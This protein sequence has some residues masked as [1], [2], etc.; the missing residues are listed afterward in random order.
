MEVLIPK[1]DTWWIDYSAAQQV[2]RLAGPFHD[3]GDPWQRISF[4]KDE[5]NTFTQGLRHLEQTSVFHQKVDG[6]IYV[7]PG[8]KNSKYLRTDASSGFDIYEVKVK[9]GWGSTHIFPTALNLVL[10]GEESRGYKS[11]GKWPLYHC[12]YATR[13]GN[14]TFQVSYTNKLVS[15][16]G[17]QWDWSM[18]GFKIHTFQTHMAKLS[19]ESSPITFVTGDHSIAGGIAAAR[20]NMKPMEIPTSTSVDIVKFFMD[21]VD[22]SMTEVRA[23]IN[24]LVHPQLF[25]DLPSPNLQSW[26]DLVHHAAGNLDANS[27]NMIAFI[28]DLKDIKSLIPKLKELGKLSTHASNYLAVEY[29]VLPTLSDLKA[30]WEAFSPTKFTDQLGYRRVSAY[31][32]VGFFHNIM[33]VDA[34]VQQTRRIHLA[35]NEL[36]TGLDALVEKARSIGIFPSLTNLWDLVPYSFVLDWF[37]DVGSVLERIDTRHR[38]LNLDI[39]YVIKTDVTEASVSDTNVKLGV[40]LS[41]L[42]KKYDRKVTTDVP[43]PRIF[44]EINKPPTAQ[45]HWVE[46]SA[47]ILQRTKN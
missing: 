23:W 30:I 10:T 8:L 21:E 47:L 18:Y 36:D 9:D 40:G 6:K 26:G 20:A 41:L 28:R 14:H 12:F 1:P 11:S 42:I 15:Q 29:G 2:A 43:Q 45:N 34:P 35:I 22:F 27:A 44:G 16:S 17:G 7:V 13:T 39:M 4:S 38:L 3:D 5:L 46:G 24:K 25:D 31:D 32:T 33:Q 19:V 37:V